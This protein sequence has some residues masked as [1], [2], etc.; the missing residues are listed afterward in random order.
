MTRF[1][2]ISILLF[3][4]LLSAQD[5]INPNLSIEDRLSILVSDYPQLEEEVELSAQNVPL[6]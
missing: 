5:G 4:G 1:I 6:T 2:L 3:S